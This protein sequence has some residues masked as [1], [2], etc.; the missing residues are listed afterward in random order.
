MMDSSSKG[1]LS[2]NFIGTIISF[3]NSIIIA[4]IFHVV[5]YYF[6]VGIDLRLEMFTIIACIHMINYSCILYQIREHV[7][8]KES[9]RPFAT[10][11]IITSILSIMYYIYKSYINYENNR[12]YIRKNDLYIVV[13]FAFES[14]ILYDLCFT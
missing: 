13:I 7:A 8:T 4:F 3:T 5:Y 14:Y 2:E 12:F 1:L 11:T 9:I 10:I 6:I